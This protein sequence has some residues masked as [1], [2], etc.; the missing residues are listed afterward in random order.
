MRLQT[1]DS[2]HVC[3]LVS[4]FGMLALH[5][6]DHWIISEISGMLQLAMF[7]YLR[8]V[9]NYFSSFWVRK[10]WI[11]QTPKGCLVGGDWNMNG[12]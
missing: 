1:T 3:C 9:V 6:N 11:H 2:L 12:L 8:V 5:K 4:D 10:K 7:D